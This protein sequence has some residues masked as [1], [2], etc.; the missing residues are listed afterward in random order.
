MEKQLRSWT[1]WTQEE[2]A[3]LFRLIKTGYYMHPR[4][5]IKWRED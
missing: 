4:L 5:P 2:D 1:R 3:E